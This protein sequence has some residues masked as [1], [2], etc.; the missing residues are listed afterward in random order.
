M[1]VL[2]NWPAH[3]LALERDALCKAR[4]ATGRLMPPN[5]SA[6]AIRDSSSGTRS[7]DLVIYGVALVD[8]A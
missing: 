2:H 6:V 8:D 4:S 1:L 3:A 5:D 7:F